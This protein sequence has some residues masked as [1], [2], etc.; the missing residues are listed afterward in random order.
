[1][2]SAR[3][4]WGLEW[5]HVH[6]IGALPSPRFGHT[7][8]VVGSNAWVFGGCDDVDG[9]PTNSTHVLH[10]TGGDCVWEAIEVTKRDAAPLE[11]WGHSVV[12]LSKTRLLLFGGFHSTKRRLNDVWI[13]DLVLLKWFPAYTPGVLND[14]EEAL[15][16][17]D[18]E[19]GSALGA[20]DPIARAVA[21]ATKNASSIREGTLSMRPSPRGDHSAAR[22]GDYFFFFGGYGGVGFEQ[23]D[24]ND[25][26]AVDVATLTWRELL[27]SGNPP[28]ARSGHSAVVVGSSMYIFGGW[29]ASGQFNDMHIFNAELMA[30]SQAGIGAEWFPGPRWAHAATAVDAIPSSRIFVFGGLSATGAVGQAPPVGTQST[31]M[32]HRRNK[33]Q[34]TYLDDLLVFETAGERV[35]VTA[36]AEEEG[37]GSESPKSSAE[38]EAA[39][40]PLLATGRWRRPIVGGERPEARSDATLNYDLR[41]AKLFLFGG[42]ADQWFGDLYSM[43]V[44]SVAGPPYAVTSMTPNVGPVTGHTHVEIRGTEFVSQPPVIVR[45]TARGRGKGMVG[46]IDVAGVYVN[47]MVVRAKTPNFEQFGGGPS[48]VRVSLR[49]DSFTSTMC[50]FNYFDVTNAKNC[51]AYGP[52]LIS[53]GSCAVPTTFIIAAFD[54]FGERRTSGGDDWTVNVRTLSGVSLSVNIEDCEDGLYEVTY[55]APREQ[56]YEI[57]VE[58]DGTFDGEEGPIRG[59]KWTVN[60]SGDFDKTRNGM[61]GPLMVQSLLDEIAALKELAE[62]TTAALD[63][64]IDPDDLTSLLRVKEILAATRTRDAEIKWRVDV[65]NASLAHLDPVKIGRVSGL[66]HQISKRELTAVFRMWQ[67][68]QHKAPMTSARLAPLVRMQAAEQK[69]ALAE[70]EEVLAE[71][72]KM[73]R[74]RRMW[75]FASTAEEALEEA[76]S[77]LE[78]QVEAWRVLG[79]KEHVAELLEFSE[80]LE[81]SRTLLVSVDE[82]L[83][84]L[85]LLWEAIDD[86]RLFIENCA[87]VPFKLVEVGELVTGTRGCQIQQAALP[88]AIHWADAYLRLDAMLK[89]FD[90]TCPLLS[91]LGHPDFRQ[92][93]WEKLLAS[94]GVRSHNSAAISGLTP[95]TPLEL[96]ASPDGSSPVV[97]DEEKLMRQRRASQRRMSSAG[98]LALDTPEDQ[99]MHPYEDEEVLLGAI[100]EL[101][102]L[103]N[104]EIISQ[105][106]DAASKEAKVERSIAD[107]ADR[108]SKLEAVPIIEA[109]GEKG[110][111]ESALGAADLLTHEV[112]DILRNDRAELQVMTSSPSAAPFL[113][114]IKSWDDA[115][116]NVTVLSIAIT[117]SQAMWRELHPLLAEAGEVK[118]ELPAEAGKFASSSTDLAKSLDFFVKNR[119]VLEGSKDTAN[120][121]RT[122]KVQKRMRECQVAVRTLI[123]GK[124]ASFPRLYFA[125][126]Y[127]LLKLL[128]TA[129]RPREAF[130]RFIPLVFPGMG[131]LLYDGDSPKGEGD[132]A[133]A[134]AD[135]PSTTT[136]VAI[137]GGRSARRQAIDDASSDATLT[138]AGWS[139]S[140]GGAE[141]VPAENSV[142]VEGTI[143]ECLQRLEVAQKVT[144]RKQVERSLKRMPKQQLT[145]WLLEE[146]PAAF[147][148]GEAA[149]S[150]DVAAAT[151]QAGIRKRVAA[152]Y[153]D[154]AQTASI[155]MQVER[156]YEVAEALNSVGRGRT[157]AMGKFVDRIIKNVESLAKLARK[158]LRPADVQRIGTMIA[159]ETHYRDLCSW[160]HQR[161]VASAGAFEWQLQ[162]RFIAIDPVAPPQPAKAERVL[163][164]DDDS[165]SDSE[166]SEEYAMHWAP[167]GKDICIE[168]CGVRCLYGYEYRGNSQRLVLTPVAERAMLSM[169]NSLKNSRGSAAIGPTRAVDTVNELTTQLGR[170]CFT[171]PCWDGLG[172]SAAELIENALLG[173]ASGTGWWAC[174]SNIDVL[175]AA[176]LSMLSNQMR[177]Y[178][179][180]MAA[181]ATALPPR[182]EEKQGEL[183]IPQGVVVRDFGRG[184]GGIVFSM[185]AT[186]VGVGN[187]GAMARLP[188]TLRVMFRPVHTLRPNTARVLERLL[189]AEGFSAESSASLAKRLEFFSVGSRQIQAAAVAAGRGGA[190]RSASCLSMD[191]LTFRR[192]IRIAGAVLRGS[193]DT[194]VVK[195][196]KEALDAVRKKAAK[197]K[198]SR[199]A[200]SKASRAVKKQERYVDPVEAARKADGVGPLILGATL[201]ECWGPRL[202]HP[203]AIDRQTFEAL[204]DELFE[205]HRN[206][207][208]VWSTVEELLGHAPFPLPTSGGEKVAD[209]ANPQAAS[210]APESTNPVSTPA[211]S[212]PGLADEE[213]AKT[214]C[215]NRRLWAHENFVKKVTQFAQMMRHNQSVIIL[216]ASGAGKSECWR[217]L[218]NM[219]GLQQHHL[220]SICSDA[221]SP[222]ELFGGY[223]GGDQSDGQ[224]AHGLLHRIVTEL[225]SAKE[226]IDGDLQAHAKANALGVDQTVESIKPVDMQSRWLVLDGSMTSEWLDALEPALTCRGA[227]AVP[228]ATAKSA[229]DKFAS[230]TTEGAAGIDAYV[231]N[232]MTANFAR[233][234]ESA[235]TA[236]GRRFAVLPNG[237]FLQFPDSM[238]IVI[239]TASLQD[240][241]PNTI[242]S[243]ALLLIQPSLTEQWNSAAFAWLQGRK[244]T[245]LVREALKKCLFL[246]VDRTLE[247]LFPGESG[248]LRAGA[249][250]NETAGRVGAAEGKVRVAANLSPLTLVNN[251]LR[252]LGGL[253]EDKYGGSGSGMAFDDEGSGD[254]DSG[255]VASAAEG[256]YE[257]IEPLFTFAAVWAFGGCLAD[258]AAKE[259]N[260]RAI[261]SRWWRETWERLDD[262]T[263]PFPL[264]TDRDLQKKLVSTA[265]ELMSKPKAATKEAKKDGDDD[266]DFSDSDSEDYDLDEP[267][268]IQLIAAA[269][270][271]NIEIA[272][273][274]DFYCDPT[275][276]TFISWDK[277]PMARI[278][279]PPSYTARPSQEIWIS[280]K[281]H[282]P[283]LMWGNML[284]E[285]G[286]AVLLAG[287]AGVGKTRLAHEMMKRRRN[288]SFDEDRTDCTTIA[289]GRTTTSLQFQT[290]LEMEFRPKKFVPTTVLARQH[291]PESGGEVWAPARGARKMCIF[292][293]DISVPEPDCAWS[294]GGSLSGA[295]YSRRSALALLRQHLDYGF[296]YCRSAGEFGRIRWID[297][298]RYICALNPQA[299]RGAPSPVC[300]RLLRQFAVLCVP[301]PSDEML[302]AIFTPFLDAMSIRLPGAMQP[303]IA[304]PNAPLLNSAM[305]LHVAVV[306]EFRGSAARPQFKWSALRQLSQIVT[307]MAA[308]SESL[309]VQ[310]KATVAGG[311]IAADASDTAVEDR[312]MRLWIHESERAYGDRLITED[313]R[314]T[315]SR[316]MEKISRKQFPNLSTTKLFRGAEPV[317]YS[318][319]SAKLEEAN[320][321]DAID[322][323]D[324]DDDDDAASVDSDDARRM[325]AMDAMGPQFELKLSN[326]AE[327]QGAPAVDALCY[328]FA[329]E[330]STKCKLLNIT[331][332]SLAVQHVTRITR[333]LLQE[334]GHAVLMGPEAAGKRT[335]ARLAASACG[336]V[337]SIARE[338]SSSAGDDGGGLG[339]L[340]TAMKTAVINGRDVVVI[341][342]IDADTMF[343]SA[344]G[345]C[346]GIDDSATPDWDVL[347]H[348]CSI[349]SGRRMWSSPG[350]FSPSQRNEF[351]GAAHHQAKTRTGRSDDD[352]THAALDVFYATELRKHF[353]VVVCVDCEA[354]STSPQ[355]QW[356]D[357]TR[358]TGAEVLARYP[359]L[360]SAAIVNWVDAADSP[361]EATQN[362][363]LDIVAR[364]VGSVR[365][366]SLGYQLDANAHTRTDVDF[367]KTD[368]GD[369]AE[370]ESMSSS[371]ED[372]DPDSDQ[373]SDEDG[374]EQEGPAKKRVNVVSL[375]L[376]HAFNTATIASN[377][378]AAENGAHAPNSLSPSLMGANGS[379]SIALPHPVASSL[380]RGTLKRF[381]F[382]IH[383]FLT[384]AK[385]NDI[386]ARTREVMLGKAL[387]KIETTRNLITN[388]ME[389][390]DRLE[391][392]AKNAEALVSEI[393]GAVVEQKVTADA[394]KAAAE[395]IYV[396]WELARKKKS[397]IAKAVAE[398]M[399]DASDDIARL[400]AVCEILLDPNNLRLLGQFKTMAKAPPGIEPVFSAILGLFAT[401]F[402]KD[403]QLVK[404]GRIT[405]KA[406][407]TSKQF[408]LGN[409]TAFQR[410]L[411]QFRVL[412]D[413]AK[414][415]NVNWAELRPY[416]KLKEFDP[417]ILAPRS[418]AGGLLCSWIISMSAF[419]DVVEAVQPAR[420]A[421]AEAEKEFNDSDALLEESKVASEYETKKLNEL[422]KALSEAITV[423]D[424]A[425]QS[426]EIMSAKVTAAK[427][428]TADLEEREA[429]W[430]EEQEMMETQRSEG[431][432][433]GKA[434]IAAAMVSLG[435]TFDTRWR[436]S[437]LTD[438][439]IPFLVRTLTMSGSVDAV[440][441]SV[442]RDAADS[443]LS[444]L[445]P[446]E[447]AVWHSY[448]LPRD[449]CFDYSGAIVTHAL[450]HKQWPLIIDPERQALT[451]LQN[452]TLHHM[453]KDEVRK[454]NMCRGQTEFFFGLASVDGVVKMES[455]PKIE[456]TQSLKASEAIAH[457]A[458]KRAQAEAGKRTL[459][460]LQIGGPDGAQRLEQGSAAGHSLLL[461]GL[462]SSGNRL[463]CPRHLQELLTL[464]SGMGRDSADSHSLACSPDTN[465]MLYTRLHDP[466]IPRTLLAECIV[467]RFKTSA[468]NMEEQLIFLMGA[469]IP[470]ALPVIEAQ[471]LLRCSMDSLDLEY[472]DHEANMLKLISDAQDADEERVKVWKQLDSRSEAEIANDA[473]MASLGG[474]GG[475]ESKMTPLVTPLTNLSTPEYGTPLT[476]DD[477]PVLGLDGML[478]A[479]SITIDGPAVVTKEVARAKEDFKALQNLTY[480]ISTTKKSLTQ[481]GLQRKGAV[482]ALDTPASLSTRAACA[483]AVESAR[484]VYELSCRELPRMSRA[485]VPSV[486]RFLEAVVRGV[487]RGVL[488]SQIKLSRDM[489]AAEELRQEEME[490]QKELKRQ[491]K[492]AEDAAEDGED[493]IVVAPK[494]AVKVAQ[495]EMEEEDTVENA[496]MKLLEADYDLVFNGTRTSWMTDVLNHVREPRKAKYDIVHAVQRA[497][498]TV[499]E[500]LQPVSITDD[501]S[502]G[503]NDG[504]AAEVQVS[505]EKRVTPLLDPK[506][507]HDCVLEELVEGYID[508]FMFEHDKLAFVVLLHLRFQELGQTREM[509]AAAEMV[510]QLKKLKKKRRKIT[511]AMSKVEAA[512]ARSRGSGANDALDSKLRD[513]ERRRDVISSAMEHWSVLLPALLGD[514]RTASAHK[515]SDSKPQAVAGAAPDNMDQAVWDRLVKVSGL[516][517][518][519]GILNSVRYNKG[520]WLT[521]LSSPSANVLN[522]PLED[523]EGEPQVTMLMKAVLVRSLRP[524]RATS[525]LARLVAANEQLGA[526]FLP[527]PFRA[528][529]TAPP[530]KVMD[531][532]A[533]GAQD[534]GGERPM[535]A[536]SRP[537][538]AYTDVTDVTDTS[539][540][541]RPTTA[542]SAWSQMSDA[543]PNSGLTA[544]APARYRWLQAWERASLGVPFVE[545][546]L[547]RLY[548]Q[549]SASA[550][551]LFMLVQDRT[552]DDVRA[553]VRALALEHHIPLE[554]TGR[555]A[556]RF[557]EV[558]LGPAGGPRQHRAYAGEAG[559]Q[560][561][562]KAA[563]TNGG[564]VMLYSLHLARMKWVD[565]LWRFLEHAADEGEGHAD[566]RCFISTAAPPVVPTGA[567]RMQSFTS[568]P[569]ANELRGAGDV[570]F[571]VEKPRT[572][573]GS[574]ASWMVVPPL[575]VQSSVIVTREAP[576]D[577]GS[578]LSRSWAVV[579]RVARSIA[580]KKRRDAEAKEAEKHRDDDSDDSDEEDGRQSSS[581][582]SKR[583]VGRTKDA[584]DPR[585]NGV[586]FALSVYHSTMRARSRFAH[587]DGGSS[588]VAFGAMSESDLELAARLVHEVL[589]DQQ[590]LSSVGGKH[591]RESS[592]TRSVM[593]L[594]KTVPWQWLR[595][596][597]GDMLFASNI[598]D[599]WDRCVHASILD[600][601]MCPSIAFEGARLPLTAPI[602]VDDHTASL[603]GHFFALAVP[604]LPPARVG[605]GAAITQ[606][607]LS[608]QDYTARIAQWQADGSVVDDTQCRAA[609]AASKGRPATAA[610]AMS[611]K[612]G[613]SATSAHGL[614]GKKGAK[615][616]QY[617]TGITSISVA[618]SRGTG[619]P[620]AAEHSSFGASSTAFLLVDTIPTNPS[621][622]GTAMQSYESYEKRRLVE[623][624]LRARRTKSALES[625]KKLLSTLPVSS[626]KSPY[627][628]LNVA[629]VLR[630]H[631]EAHDEAARKAAAATTTV[632]DDGFDD[633]GGDPDGEGGEDGD[634]G[635]REGYFEQVELTAE[636]VLA[637][638]R[639][640]LAHDARV[641]G[642]KT[643]YPI[644]ELLE[645]FQ[646]PLVRCCGAE[647]ARMNKLIVVVRN[648]LH[649]FTRSLNGHA[650]MTNECA[651]IAFALGIAAASNRQSIDAAQAIDVRTVGRSSIPASWMRECGSS[652][653]A[654]GADEDL[655]TWL[656]NLK[657]RVSQLDAWAAIFLGAAG[658]ERS[659]R[660]SNFVNHQIAIF[661]MQ[662]ARGDDDDDDGGGDDNS[663]VGAESTYGGS[664]SGSRAS[665]PATGAAPQLKQPLLLP[666]TLWLAG[667]FDPGAFVSH[668]LQATGCRMRAEQGSSKS[669]FEDLALEI[670]ISDIVDRESVAEMLQG[671]RGSTPAGGRRKKGA[672]KRGGGGGPSLCG[673]LVHGMH[674]RGAAWSNSAGGG[675]GGGGEARPGSG[676]SRASGASGQ[677]STAGSRSGR[678]TAGGTPGGGGG[679]IDGVSCS[680]MLLPII[681]NAPGQ[682]R[683]L[684]TQPL[685][686]VYLRV[687]SRKLLPGEGCNFA[688]FG[689]NLLQHQALRCGDLAHDASAP[690]TGAAAQRAGAL[691]CPV[692]PTVARPCDH[693][694]G[695]SDCLFT[696]QV[697]MSGTVGIWARGNVAL[698]LQGAE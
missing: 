621:L 527:A 109:A 687:V 14:E 636:E 413:E 357:R 488:R 437:L 659:V 60:F 425:V 286:H 473:I 654:H 207:S 19:G 192:L 372:S 7:T 304:P 206:L 317:V 383:S 201:R 420:D 16:A 547:P 459:R 513:A 302:E 597:I 328:A 214:A 332:F 606:K 121:K 454:D 356:R 510:T 22:I 61:R 396:S 339:L 268:Q 380:E 551:M 105:I 679:K 69:V 196:S 117:A 29:S 410:N 259:A 38:S 518:L 349:L 631:Q 587:R 678:S 102:L 652:A 362:A 366:M 502:E 625:V 199:K 146:F 428:L 62:I 481:L 509:A 158:Q 544:V 537:G 630:R 157:D 598:T 204:L 11:R 241:T 226:T 520:G 296:W 478:E 465:I 665:R 635:G 88:M 118:R 119:M 265:R 450:R 114:D 5:E 610:S 620:Y 93:H 532:Y 421:L 566:F 666:P 168:S 281:F 549:C 82:D 255:S 646:L 252:M 53:G 395:E 456:S 242:T 90:S 64:D 658:A 466:E 175:P 18:E 95:L 287:A 355:R 338:A 578:C 46:S 543:E 565:W 367:S 240:A 449:P 40:Q 153:A 432:H 394:A 8:T 393:Q 567:S 308:A 101:P 151:K 476:G 523:V 354:P 233:S 697:P 676:S 120:C 314:I 641:R 417:D 663:A 75:S 143:I 149:M 52:G 73:E 334:G 185:S 588:G 205:G 329:S 563:V 385:A 486:H 225:G 671:A 364:S 244:E 160:L 275:S 418:A 13:F 384:I 651:E 562:L 556:S 379:T 156:C 127:E 661:D 416:L 480:N 461:L 41:N 555:D 592:S 292:V 23:R 538:T 267:T 444:V 87:E 673:A 30:W 369:D 56:A 445:K 524:D 684:V 511:H 103:M 133:G 215:L 76:D 546:L 560:A 183:E 375:F 485:Y 344:D 613:F 618:P 230:G 360:A 526:H 397:R 539:G 698:V 152:R 593:E 198:V 519:E 647:C 269:H 674:I 594:G 135:G 443:M 36:G 492:A 47:D 229:L 138:I 406:W 522:I 209:A 694:K 50:T 553:W 283:L 680:G 295:G 373:D 1:M 427:D 403:K 504:D 345:A 446:R 586:L 603:D 479:D 110:S 685:P 294:A 17:E 371:E 108:W 176:M 675:G 415:P 590:A 692:Y 542:N 629:D 337:V 408:L 159:F 382:L 31:R 54:S 604:P 306:K 243:T 693:A 540:G 460:F 220:R 100:L 190:E 664:R 68:A 212:D 439:W 363:L 79:K 577:Y 483:S 169:L 51:L 541:S 573:A 92:R 669:I 554:E 493:A 289:L 145:D 280:N 607:A 162:L 530:P 330:A 677:G 44:S 667:L 326:Y 487:K 623:E 469:T 474:S 423:R 341:I 148:A 616:V 558:H 327:L 170:A 322:D 208:I 622:L 189:L 484:I 81:R 171:L 319:L 657:T 462:E 668:L 405:N 515:S 12:Q 195:V 130:A 689:D 213:A 4:T 55:T 534:Y 400:D 605:F 377:A 624:K 10:I 15:D 571:R 643:V 305:M 288:V 248:G 531:W 78:E 378:A 218:A 467:V 113:S 536:M 448:S 260:P 293:D 321:L 126:Q 501:P 97:M 217:T 20:A 34:G 239:E 235:A 695:E 609:T 173:L 498:D 545:E 633:G 227:I 89:E 457:A 499:V 333:V 178:W 177:A 475:A 39:P 584:G 458:K 626:I 438:H 65:C 512:K 507:L 276:G 66:N 386:E 639:A 91:D 186:S 163:G 200:S 222:S 58:F 325:E 348:V 172:Y 32:R 279:A 660:I 85:R 431:L 237:E 422:T 3:S 370:S 142:A 258:G 434:L 318:N 644:E 440:G 182:V 224:W 637:Q 161:K 435:G 662:N 210:L 253:L 42:F 228:P 343:N 528:M 347:P 116:A 591:A 441:I 84:N 585:V 312:L 277:H 508:P 582:R 472:I 216:G 564:W 71:Y 525:A 165:G 535:T 256:V 299:L 374:E 245:E 614:A 335:I 412:T 368:G 9:M 447:V 615:G 316:A 300:P 477:S 464:S 463:A 656:H 219:W 166:E 505:A 391:M 419:H 125:P 495:S 346:D 37:G 57:E 77:C 311:E 516:P 309:K 409:V 94:I 442:P 188:Q 254:D 26:Y 167:V 72:V 688:G 310:I 27:P 672:K 497:N 691:L 596:V 569:F 451:W 575:L 429:A 232:A 139:S 552:D 315:F 191:A 686:V 514:L 6:C 80:L 642:E 104:R 583:K 140:T 455:T 517:G 491:K 611:A 392:D 251:L 107:L 359:A 351:E 574:A 150:F 350:L 503:G 376:R 634:G 533:E 628:S 468:A 402:I 506:S 291:G 548:R 496:G 48:D 404:D 690:G 285:R 568:L 238:R 649:N 313:E 247:F 187:A 331:M 388:I 411:E 653:W 436:E 122:E 381:T 234:S 70:H 361:S 645:P 529:F 608:W 154:S 141:R 303:M 211:P 35:T 193:P 601:I 284:L 323:D 307:G 407:D 599:P 132:A 424:V 490:R 336:H 123:N 602:V 274:F 194:T 164:S 223:V 342:Q 174:I 49:G 627:D 33:A 278:A 43:D 650:D 128:S 155:T 271:A 320:L 340:R 414:V 179:D 559:A 21:I 576:T 2:A 290:S 181:A 352:L 426:F 59:S 111:G 28:A 482:S 262:A 231:A 197:K 433:I 696:A 112:K 272:S 494:K 550:P 471:I 24:F 648:S 257:E 266:D 430:T 399:E 500:I 640:A 134:A 398:E 572:G 390:L 401:V 595:F 619:L 387:S 358:A 63:E 365:V 681:P 96:G 263:A 581:R 589:A 282:A 453:W 180:G 250:T 353:H 129:G 600:S 301:A 261:F 203:D 98:M 670:H 579:S 298:A 324:D 184:G 83:V 246:Y 270:A 249:S 638:K 612:S 86:A 632:V 297:D 45:F 99:F 25:I 221:L 580:Y 115:L 452:L 124:R 470:Q 144:M 655:M 106:L 489:R 617:R 131:R 264:T 682:P 561:A 136:A 389:T 521:W 137:S 236:S 570:A 67:D 147:E 557:V 74:S 273:V 683:G 202:G